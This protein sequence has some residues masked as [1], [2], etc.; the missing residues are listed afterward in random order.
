MV[1]SAKPQSPKLPSRHSRLSSFVEVTADG[2]TCETKKTGKCS[3]HP[4]LQWNEDL[5]L[6]VTPQSR[7]DLKV[8]NCHTLRK[9]LLGSATIDLLDTLRSHDGKMENLQLSLVLQTENKGAVVAGGELTVCLDGLA[10]D[11]GSLPNGN[12]ATGSE[13]RL[14]VHYKGAH[15]H[16][17]TDPHTAPHRHMQK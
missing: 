2:L 16:A 1:L 6:N 15:K 11:L 10:V 13:A 12:A 9:E 5:T 17:H 8:W 3:G 14:P 4:E 7:L